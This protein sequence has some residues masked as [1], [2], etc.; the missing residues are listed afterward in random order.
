MN[1]EKPEH[2]MDYLP[3]ILM[4]VAILAIFG[5]FVFIVMD[6]FFS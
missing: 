6:R 5:T 1:D 2:W 4:L 3:V